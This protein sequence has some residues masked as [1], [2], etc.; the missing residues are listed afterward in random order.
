MRLIFLF[1]G[2]VFLSACSGAEGTGGTTGGLEAT[3]SSIQE[4]IFT[5]RCVSCH[6]PGGQGY[7]ETEPS[8]LDLSSAEVSFAGL[9]NVE[10]VQERCGT[11][12]DQSCGLRVAPGDPDSSYL[13]NKLTGEG[14]SFATDPMPQS[15]EPLTEEE[16]NA[17]RQWIEAGALDN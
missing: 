13:M 7:V 6:T 2:G 15:A 4:N 14:L 8:P 9:V 1:L 10:S 5:P 12:A 3:L 11:S 16:I 17:I